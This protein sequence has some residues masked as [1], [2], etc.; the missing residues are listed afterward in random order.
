MVSGREGFAC[1]DWELAP[2]NS[3]SRFPSPKAL[4][5]IAITPAGKFAEGLPVVVWYASE[6]VYRTAFPGQFTDCLGCL[7]LSA[8]LLSTPKP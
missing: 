6:E 7:P 1:F 8:L 4:A 3:P 2:T 5:E